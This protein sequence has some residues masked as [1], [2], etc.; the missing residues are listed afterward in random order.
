MQHSVKYADIHAAYVLDSSNRALIED[1]ADNCPLE[2]GDLVFMARRLL[3]SIG[4]DTLEVTSACEE[5]YYMPGYS[6]KQ[7]SPQENQQQ[8]M[9]YPNPANQSVFIQA[10]FTGEFTLMDM[11]GRNLRSGTMEA[12][13]PVEIAVLN[14]PAGIYSIAFS[15]Q[16]IHKETFKLVITH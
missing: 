11:M 4:G 16:G 3:L 2:Y 14:I 6:P 12:D 5:D 9:V 8:V 10:S 7:I 13:I 1:M 15:E